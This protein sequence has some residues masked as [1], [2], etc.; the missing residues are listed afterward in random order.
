MFQPKI[1]EPYITKN[2]FIKLKNKQLIFLLFL[3]QEEE[4]EEEEYLKKINLDDDNNVLFIYA[5]DFISF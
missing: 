2:E 3:K 1:I 5:Y 4:E